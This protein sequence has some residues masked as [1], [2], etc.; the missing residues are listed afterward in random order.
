MMMKI[1]NLQ[2]F[3]RKLSSKSRILKQFRTQSS[4]VRNDEFVQPYENSEIWHVCVEHNGS[5]LLQMLWSIEKSFD[6]VICPVD[7]NE[8]YIIRPGVILNG[9]R[10]KQITETFEKLVQG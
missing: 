2:G 4:K 9:L 3:I 8:F 10:R 5:A 7:G 6:F 1:E